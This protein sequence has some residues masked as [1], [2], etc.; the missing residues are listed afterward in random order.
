[1][2]E[3]EGWDWEA[4]EGSWARFMDTEPHAHPLQDRAAR[5]RSPQPAEQW[6]QGVPAIKAEVSLPTRVLYGTST[7]VCKGSKAACALTSYIQDKSLILLWIVKM[8]LSSSVLFS[9]NQESPLTNDNVP[10]KE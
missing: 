5:T 10:Y 3:R 7:K 1:M 2:S 9:A 4:A 8:I 6:L